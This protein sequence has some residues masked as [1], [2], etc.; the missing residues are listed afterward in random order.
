V[1]AEQDIIA[2]IQYAKK[3][4]AK[5][6]L[7]LWGSSYSSSLVIRIAAEH[8]DMV[9]GSLSFAPGEYF[10]NQGKSA[11]WITSSAKKIKCPVFITS[12]KNEE[13]N[14]ANIYKA[15][16][17]KTKEKFLPTSKGNHGSRA[18]WEEFDDHTQYWKATAGFL[19]QFL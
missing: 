19:A 16:P 12:A 4:L 17:T 1:D 9:D 14:W 8:P 15:I 3:K 18:L 7:I 5:G 11:D 13:K 2:A 10:K 6:K